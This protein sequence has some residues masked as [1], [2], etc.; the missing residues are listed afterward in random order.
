MATSASSDPGV[1]ALLPTANAEVS[2]TLEIE[3]EVTGKRAI[4]DVRYYVDWVQVRRTTK[5]HGWKL[6]TTKLE[7]GKH[8]IRVQVR[9]AKGRTSSVNRRIRVDNPRPKSATSR[10]RVSA[11][12]PRNGARVSG[13]LRI[14]PTAKSTYGIRDV[15][16]YV[17][18]KKVRRT[19]KSHRW[20]L[21]TA[22]LAPGR[23]HI[24]VQVRDKRGRTS[25]I[26]RKIV[27][28]R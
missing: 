20:V 4:R 11:N 19:T 10:P 16:Y 15:R 7:N 27:V 5:S 1:S 18:W 12:L 28:R 22:K 25:S 24:R 17:D 14:R 21:D 9:D 6:D 8:H 23:H 2:G 13:K 26:N 3:P